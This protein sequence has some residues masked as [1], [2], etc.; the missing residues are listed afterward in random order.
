MQFWLSLRKRSKAGRAGSIGRVV[1]CRVKGRRVG[2]EGRVVR[3]GGPFHPRCRD[4][5]GIRQVRRLQG[6]SE[7]FLL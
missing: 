6:L 2:Y 7:I 4:R 5:A 1:G 3:A